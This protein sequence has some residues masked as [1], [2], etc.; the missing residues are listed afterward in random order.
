[1]AGAKKG[2]SAAKGSSASKQPRVPPAVEN[3]VRWVVGPGRPAALAVLVT[4]LF[5]GA[6]ALIWEAVGPD[7]QSSDAYWLT[8]ESVEITPL[9]EWIRSNI[10]RDVFRD[11]SM[12]GALSIMDD[13]LVD[14]LRSGFALNPWVAKVI[15]VRK[16]HP[17]RVKV[18]LVYRRPVCVVAIGEERLP[19][20]AQGV[21][22]PGGDLSP[23]E[24]ARYPRLVGIETRPLTSAGDRWADPR[25]AG[26]AEIAAALQPVWEKLGL[27]SIVPLPVEEVGRAREHRYELVTRGGT[28]V[29]WGRSPSS[30]P[31]E[32]PAAEKIDKLQKYA[33]EHGTLEG[34]A[35]RQMLDLTQPG[36]IEVRPQTAVAPTGAAR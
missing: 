33:A 20:D 34:T 15:S 26:G 8:P 16:H 7:V 1:M 31:G 13:D 17:A 5:F 27:E 25:V 19:V 6:A 21:L 24:A 35:G 4:G 23:V 10:R 18:D 36:S 30:S 32:V 14:R 22:L 9:P 11:A 28:R 29:F 12:D 3:A 2:N